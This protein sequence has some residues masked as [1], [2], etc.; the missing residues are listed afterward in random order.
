MYIKCEQ[1]ETHTVQRIR[2][3]S[4]RL[5]QINAISLVRFGSKSWSYSLYIYIV[6]E[7]HSSGNYPSQFD[8]IIFKF[9]I[10]VKEHGNITVKFSSTISSSIC[11][12]VKRI[13][14]NAQSVSKSYLPLSSLDPSLSTKNN[15]K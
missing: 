13:S 15:Y 7:N 14:L 10:H 3:K 11:S 9:D 8:S 5:L 12:Y 4:C 1:Q 2:Y 6:F